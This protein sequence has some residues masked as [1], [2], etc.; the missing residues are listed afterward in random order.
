MSQQQQR[1]AAAAAADQASKS[2][3]CGLQEQRW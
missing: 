3:F 2:Q 1:A